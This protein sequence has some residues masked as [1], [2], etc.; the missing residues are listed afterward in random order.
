MS[1]GFKV[2]SCGGTT[3]SLLI[4]NAKEKREKDERILGVFC[5]R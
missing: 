5:E 4:F 2:R 3:F 1:A